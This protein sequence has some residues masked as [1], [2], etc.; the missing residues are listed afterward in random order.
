MIGGVESKSELIDEATHS[1]RR[2]V[3]ELEVMAVSSR[4]N[5]AGER[6]EGLFR[7]CAVAWLRAGTD[8]QNRRE[9]SARGHIG[10]KAIFDALRTWCGPDIRMVW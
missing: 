5:E 4:R 7:T 9:C 6:G 2:A 8:R 1:W 3:Q 10:D